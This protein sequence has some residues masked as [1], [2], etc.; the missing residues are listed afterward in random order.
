MILTI[1]K[2][3]K[4][5]DNGIPSEWTRLFPTD[6]HIE[7]KLEVKHP[8]ED[9]V[10]ELVVDKIMPLSGAGVIVRLKVKE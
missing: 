4:L 1:D 5:V 6:K 3:R 8:D 2:L 7:L 9:A 10:T